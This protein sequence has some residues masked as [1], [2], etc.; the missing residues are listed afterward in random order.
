[1]ASKTEL[2]DLLTRK[3]GVFLGFGLSSLTERGDTQPLLPL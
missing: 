3:Y 1:M 2:D